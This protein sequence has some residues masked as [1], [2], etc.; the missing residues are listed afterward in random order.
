MSEIAGSQFHAFCEPVTGVLHLL[1]LRPV[2]VDSKD[3]SEFDGK[4]D[5]TS[6]E[7]DISNSYK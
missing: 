5:R 7:L 3:I 4:R 2:K 6:N 1:G